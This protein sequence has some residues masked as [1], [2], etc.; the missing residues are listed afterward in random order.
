MKILKKVWIVVVLLGLSLMV[1]P[2]VKESLAA[3]REAAEEGEIKIVYW[4]MWDETEPQ[5]KAL[6]LA[7]DEY[8]KANP[9]IEFEVVWNGREN[10]TLAR[11]A[12]QAG[13]TIDLLDTASGPLFGG[14]VKE[15]FA[16]QLDKYL[17]QPALGEKN[18]SVR[19]IISVGALNQY[20]KDGK[21]Y[22]LPYLSYTVQFWYNK[23]IF[24]EAGAQPP[25]TWDEFLK[26]CDAILKT[27][28]TPIVVEG[29]IESY[30]HIWLGY[31]IQRMKGCDFLLQTVADKSGKMWRDPVYIQAA[32]AI[33]DLWEKGYIPDDAKGN[34]WP[35]GQQS[36]GLG[37][38]AME[39]MGSWL[40]TEIRDIAGPDFRWGA[41]GFPAI[42]GGRG[43]NTD[44]MMGTQSFIILKETQHPDEAFEFLQYVLRKDII[45][46]GV[47]IALAGTPRLG[48]EWPGPLADGA[49]AMA[50]AK[51]SFDWFCG[52]PA[53]YGEFTKNILNI[54]W[55]D[56]FL[57]NITP[58]EFVQKMQTQAVKYWA[59]QE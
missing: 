19:D 42:K 36:L 50:Q 41:F 32:R 39:L 51:V 21:I 56:V 15:G 55:R 33:R 38:A 44:L 34:V 31:Y 13:E 27:G 14:L 26:V 37:E 29:D 24:E 35:A 22:M 2:A 28:Y 48:V 7:I 57:G 43:S 58:D 49:E 30:Q 6:K 17:D 25:E 10:Q 47:N 12:L 9:H 1:Y 40:P 45:Q 5:A 8:K 18:R 59:A 11:T 54:N 53:Q 4:S 16:L 46:E 3:N 23:D 52:V 20:A